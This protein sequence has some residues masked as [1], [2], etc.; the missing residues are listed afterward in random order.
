MEEQQEV[1][2]R[3]EDDGGESETEFEEA[4]WHGLPES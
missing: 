3:R 2:G 1:R 4:G